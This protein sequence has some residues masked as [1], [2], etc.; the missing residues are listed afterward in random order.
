MEA[1][2]G[3][4]AG[5]RGGLTR[6]C[7]SAPP[8][9]TDGKF[10]RHEWKQEQRK[11]AGRFESS[12][13]NVDN[14][15]VAGVKLYGLMDTYSAEMAEVF[16]ALFDPGTGELRKDVKELLGDVPFRNIL[17][18]DRVEIL[19]AYR[20]M[21]LGLATIW[22]IIQR[23]CGGITEP[24]GAVTFPSPFPPPPHAGRRR[25]AITVTT[26]KYL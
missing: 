3:V 12:Y 26:V 22:D 24:P 23:H 5:E 4:A 6:P 11:A 2:A 19:P 10:A 15:F 13:S 18:I 1:S 25:S 20:G 17:V 9:P 16:E 21:G 14:S 7:F 8:S